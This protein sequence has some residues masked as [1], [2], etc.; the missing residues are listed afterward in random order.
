MAAGTGF[1]LTART[2]ALVVTG[3]SADFTTTSNGTYVDVTGLT[4]SVPNN[5][6]VSARYDATKSTAGTGSCRLVRGAGPTVVQTG[7][8]VGTARKTKFFNFYQ[9][10]SG[11]AETW[12]VQAQSTADGN[13]FTVHKD[14]LANPAA[15]EGA[16]TVLICAPFGIGYFPAASYEISLKANFTS[17][18]A[19]TIN[20][21]YTMIVYGSSL[22]Q[23]PTS[24]TTISINNIVEKFTIS[25]TATVAYGE[26]GASANSSGIMIF[27]DFTG[28]NVT[29]S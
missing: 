27:Y 18:S 4:Y 11:A 19:F 28:D 29:L 23:F 22:P 10:Q 2:S 7:A 16:A 8:T 13:T 15:Q 12:K 9:N 5:H 20:N 17:L 3:L 14:A 1:T 24:A 6:F 25:T 21:G 26:G